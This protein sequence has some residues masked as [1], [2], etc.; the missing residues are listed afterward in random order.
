MTTIS[1]GRDFARLLQAVSTVPAFDLLLKDFL[2]NPAQF[3]PDF[4][5]IL[6]YC[7]IPTKRDYL[8]SLVTP[9]MEF[10][11][12]FLLNEVPEKMYLP[13]LARFKVRHLSTRESETLYPDLIRFIC[14]I[15]QP[16]I[17]I[18]RSKT[19]LQ[20]WQIIKS[21][22]AC[23]QVIIMIENNVIEHHRN[24]ISEIVFLY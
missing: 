23:I 16:R 5:G 11:I 17:E 1:L 7:K 8:L 20:R 21:L 19:N 12:V 24:S 22:F 13:Y 6:H 15:V 4:H 9:D 14:Y 3:H 18:I 2:Y 10:K